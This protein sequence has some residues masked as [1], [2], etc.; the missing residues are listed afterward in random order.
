MLCKGCRF[1]KLVSAVWC[2][3]HRAAPDNGLSLPAC[4]VAW[5][6][7]CVGKMKRGA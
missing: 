3:S 6:E 7:W 1:A 2:C 4:A 5:R